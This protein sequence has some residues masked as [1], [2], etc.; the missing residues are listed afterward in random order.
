MAFCGLGL[1]FLVIATMS[2]VGVYQAVLFY[3]RAVQTILLLLVV[4]LFLAMGRPVTW[5][6]PRC[7]GSAPGSRPGSAT[8]AAKVLTFPAITTLVLVIVPFLVY[9]TS[10]YEAGFHSV[11]VRNLTHLAL[12]VPGFVFFWTLLRV[13]PVP[14]AY[15]YLVVALGHRRGGGR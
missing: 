9:F 4:P 15:P 8:Q 2:W 13:D 10:W 3:A 12:M 5:R 1:G 11:V 7:P 14:K 6:S